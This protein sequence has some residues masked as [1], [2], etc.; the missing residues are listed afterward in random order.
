MYHDQQRNRPHEKHN[1]GTVRTE[2]GF[3]AR[4]LSLNLSICARGSTRVL[5]GL[6]QNVPTW[7]GTDPEHRSCPK[8]PQQ[9]F[10]SGVLL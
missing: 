9:S 2:K 6:G 3:S 7:M 5:L 8:S 1:W 4:C 10:Q